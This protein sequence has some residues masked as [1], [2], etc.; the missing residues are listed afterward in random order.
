M[1]V[2]LRQLRAFVAVYRSGSFTRAAEDLHVT[3]PALS[4]MIKKMELQL[5]ID[6]FIRS[7]RETVPT[8]AARELLPRVEKILSDLD[9]TLSALTNPVGGQVTVA[10]IPSVSALVLPPMIAEFEAKHARVRIVVRDAMTE[11]QRMI[12]LLKAGEFDCALGVAPPKE[13][14]LQFSPILQDRMA[15]VVPRG[16]PLA[17]RSR[18]SWAQIATQPL[19]TT[20]DRS[21]VRMLVDQA[22]ASNGLSV[23][24]KAE[25]SLVSTV[26]GMVEA[27]LGVGLLPDAALLMSKSRRIVGVPLVEPVISREI[28]FVHRPVASLSSTTRLFLRFAGNW[29]ASRQTAD[30]ANTRRPR[31]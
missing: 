20:T 3:Q 12:D 21:N 1:D 4:S 26:L 22:F 14:N 31:S 13:D 24:P 25:V 10:S 19:I 5:G 2:T 15:A 8:P 6:L 29:V 30:K 16:H 11:S 17:K 23:K 9:T 27:G 28:G 7:Q 18:L